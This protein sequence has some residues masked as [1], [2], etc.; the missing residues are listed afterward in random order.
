MNADEFWIIN[1]TVKI[2]IKDSIKVKSGFKHIEVA[3]KD[4]K[5]E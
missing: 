3:K 1:L 2:A 4:R 5:S